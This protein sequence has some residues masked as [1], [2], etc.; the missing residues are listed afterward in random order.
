VIRLRVQGHYGDPGNGGNRD[1]VT[2]RAI[3]YRPASPDA[4]WPPPPYDT[5]GPVIDRPDVADRYQAPRRR[6]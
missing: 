4:A 1:A 5:P 3:G 2:W 6:P